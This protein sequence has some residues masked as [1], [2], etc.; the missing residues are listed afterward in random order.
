MSQELEVEN[1]DPKSKDRENPFSFKSFLKRASES[2]VSEAAGQKKGGRKSMQG[3]KKD[4]KKS[5][6]TSGSVLSEEISPLELATPGN[7]SKGML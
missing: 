7:A 1:T 3:R 2:D 4:S 6:K 5:K